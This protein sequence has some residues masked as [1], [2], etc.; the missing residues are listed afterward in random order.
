MRKA[1]SRHFQPPIN[2]PEPL[3]K[4]AVNDVLEKL[5]GR[6]PDGYTFHDVEEEYVVDPSTG[7]GRWQQVKPT[8][9][10]RYHAPAEAAPTG[11]QA[12]AQQR[13]KKRGSDDDE[14]MYMSDMTDSD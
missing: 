10:Q 6:P 9:Q 4:D 1:R 2:I 8:K 5:A 7:Q 3:M 14:D 12:R 11:R 13:K